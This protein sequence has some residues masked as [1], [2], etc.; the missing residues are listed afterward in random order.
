MDLEVPDFRQ[1]HMEVSINGG[2]SIARWFRMEN[3][4]DDLGVPLF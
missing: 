4:I 3:P 2:T 1:S